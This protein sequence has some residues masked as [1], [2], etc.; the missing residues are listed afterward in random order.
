MTGFDK[1][2]ARFD[3]IVSW[4]DVIAPLH[5]AEWRIRAHDAPAWERQLRQWWRLGDEP[6]GLVLDS[7]ADG[8]SLALAEIFAS[9]QLALCTG[10]ADAYAPTPAGLPRPLGLRVRELLHLDLL[11]GTAPLCLSEFG[12]P[13]RALPPQAVRDAVAPVTSP[14][15]PAEGAALLVA[16]SEPELCELLTH[17]RAAGYGPVVAVGLPSGVRLRALERTAREQSAPLTVVE[18]PQVT[19]ALYEE[20]RPAALV[21][22]DPSLLLRARALYGVTP[23][24]RIPS[25]R[26]ADAALA[27]AA[28]APLPPDLAALAGALAYTEQ[29][30][31]YASLRPEAAAYLRAAGRAPYFP[32]RRLMALGLPGGAPAPLRP[33]LRTSTLPRLARAALRN[34]RLRGAAKRMLARSGAARGLAARV[35][36]L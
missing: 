19:E 35:K 3:R 4:H 27:T 9:A 5:P 36:G 21:S 23:V 2:S 25:P 31:V 20:L 22:A 1:L 12:V 33:L 32:R 8:Q 30:R 29:P 16:P 15:G 14:G 26:T 13:V 24:P 28:A 6:V 34:R 10:G 11:P 17:A 18:P 7:L